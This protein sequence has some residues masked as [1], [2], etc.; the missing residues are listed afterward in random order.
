MLRR[1]KI[2]P[3]TIVMTSKPVLT[4][5]SIFLLFAGNMSRAQDDQTVLTGPYLGQETPGLI[6]EVFAPGIVSTEH[7]D[8]SGFFSPDMQEFYFTRK[9]NEDG[10]WS[11][12]KYSS[13]QGEWRQSSVTPRVG[14]PILSPDGK[15]MHLGTR[16][17]TR[18]G[19]GWSETENL[20]APYDDIQVMRLMSSANGTYV[21]DE[22][23]SDGK[24]QLRYARIIDGKRE[25]PTPFGPEVNAG[26][27]NAHPYIAPDESYLIWDG[28]RRSG[29]GDNDLYVSFRQPDG[30]WGE[31][32]NLGDKINTEAQEGGAVVTPDGKYLFFNRS[33]E[34]GNGDIYW[35]D[36]QLIEDLRYREAN[37]LSPE[38]TALE[39]EIKHWNMPAIKRN[40]WHIPLLGEAW[41]DTSPEDKNDGIA[42]GELGVDGG[43]KEMI[44]ALVQEI[45]DKQH[46]EVDSLLIS[47]R[48]KLLFESYFSRGR[49][50]LSHPQSSTTK[51][52]TVLAL[53]R[54]IQLGYLSLADL[55]KPIVDFLE[56]L[57]S[58]KFV[59]GAE[60]ITLHDALN[61][62][63]GLQISDEHLA[64]YRENP[65]RYNG[66]RQV[67]AYLEDSAPI[68]KTNQ[69]FNYLGA[70]PIMIM[71]VLDAV[72]PG[73]AENFIRSEF[74]GKLGITNYSWLTDQSGLPKGETGASLTSRDMLKLGMTV[75]NSGR[76]QGEQFLPEEFVNRFGQKHLRLTM[77]QSQ[78]F[79]EGDKLS[80][81]GYAY[82]WWPLDMTVGDKTY[83][84]TSA[85]GAGGV[86]IIV[87]EELDLLL[88]VTGHSTEAFLQMI[89]EK[90][91]PAFIQ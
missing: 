21:L 82:F 47:K 13:E 2:L 20:G 33:S 59:E 53:G 60:T 1:T 64:K 73:S 74:F 14:R 62:N 87:I 66:I 72:V 48:G 41:V 3:D 61:M 79:Y 70:N 89:A 78:A 40:F 5:F 24:G 37:N 39:A 30:S 7:R 84:T 81:P 69:Q 46:N 9:N 80:N 52:Y 18:V 11:L 57:D 10:Q 63:S 54:A 91:L 90:I 6:P 83:Q 44:M 75:I 19:D 17:K 50:N 36:A 25:A 68:T 22:A 35:V 43:N 34:A 29:Y 56:G 31:A 4:I 86:T 65:E 8:Y 77:E 28:E 76:W 55:D 85:Q 58:S 67:Q 71:Q 27:W 32:T 51:A 26:R 15:I 45:A 49:I 42:V 88:V 38:A 23:K 12:I 16:F